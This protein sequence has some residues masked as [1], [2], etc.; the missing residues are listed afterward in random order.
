MGLT[1]PG[2]PVECEAHCR[3]CDRC[4]GCDDAFDRH[5]AGSHQ[6]QN[7]R[8]ID[9]GRSRR[10]TAHKGLCTIARPGLRHRYVYCL[11]GTAV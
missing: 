4:F 8:C 10:L 1:K 11:P 7:R 9:A 6:G 5:R 3:S 2:M